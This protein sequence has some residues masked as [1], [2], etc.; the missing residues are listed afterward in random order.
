VLFVLAALVLLGVLLAAGVW[1]A[2]P[3]H[4][5]HLSHAPASL[6]PLA[7]GPPPPAQCPGG[8]SLPCF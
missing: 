3:A 1:F 7:D 5:I 8:S 6:G 4:L 2:D